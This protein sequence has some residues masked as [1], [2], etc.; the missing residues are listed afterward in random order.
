MG[1]GLSLLLVCVA[2]T[3][4]LNLNTFVHDPRQRLP[5]RHF[6]V[7]ATCVFQHC[8][9]GLRSGT[10]E[11]A[12]EPGDAL[13]MWAVKADEEHTARVFCD[14]VHDAKHTRCLLRPV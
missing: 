2:A 4:A 8:T 6:A 5:Y 10:A 1:E 11:I 13:G 3:L 14:P 7:L 12:V 9:G